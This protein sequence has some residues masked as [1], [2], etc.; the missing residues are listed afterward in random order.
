MMAILFI[1]SITSVFTAF[2]FGY[3]AT[4]AFY[5]RDKPSRD[6]PSDLLVGTWRFTGVELGQPRDIV[7]HLRPDGTE[8]YIINGVSQ[9]AGT[10]QYIDAH[11]YERYPD[12]RKGK[13]AIQIRDRDHFE[14]TIVDNGIPAQTGLRRL[15]VRE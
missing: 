8:T 10:W 15:Y 6:N 3:P 4:L 13:G 5:F 1:L 9:G 7:W 2:A 12:G 11:I 14:I